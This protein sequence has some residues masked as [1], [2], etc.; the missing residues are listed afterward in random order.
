MSRKLVENMDSCL[1]PPTYLPHSLSRV[2]VS[3]LAALGGHAPVL[4]EGKEILAAQACLVKE[5]L[6]GKGVVLLP[7][8]WRC[9]Q[10]LIIHFVFIWINMACHP[11]Y[12][13]QYD[14]FKTEELP[15]MSPPPDVANVC[16]AFLLS[17]PS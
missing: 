15:R 8:Q 12:S 14:S 6:R 9:P 16:K 7:S 2:G 4:Q 13:G 11:T 17:S 10:V 3:V 5:S 1:S